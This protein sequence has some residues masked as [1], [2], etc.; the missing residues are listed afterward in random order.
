MFWQLNRLVSSADAANAELKRVRQE[1]ELVRL[2]QQLEREERQ[3][4]KRRAA[5][6]PEQRAE[7]DRQKAEEE[8]RHIAEEEA[9]RVAK[10]AAA[11]RQWE[12]KSLSPTKL[13]CG[14]PALPAFSGKLLVSGGM[15]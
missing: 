3:E 9:R 12:E 1:L 5:L 10:A 6:T 7:E 8:A 11:K 13:P 4:E 14:N 15:L 2:E